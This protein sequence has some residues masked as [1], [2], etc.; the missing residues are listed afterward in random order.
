MNNTTTKTAPKGACDQMGHALMRIVHAFAEADEDAKIFLA[1]WDIKDGFW[2]LNAE[3]GQEWNFSYVMPQ[4]PGEPVRLVV[5]TSLQMGWIESP[6]YFCAAS[7]TARDVAVQYAETEVGSLPVHKF[8]EFTR[9]GK[10]Y[11][12]LPVTA[13]IKDPFAYLVEVF[14]DDYIA[15]AIPTSREQL[16]H[17]ATAVM[18]GV[19]DMFPPDANDEEDSLAL[20]KLKKG[21]SKW[22]PLK[23]VLGFD[24]DGVKK[25]LWLESEKRDVILT[26]LHGWL[27][28]A[29]TKAH[30]IKY[31]EFESTIGKVR[32]AF[33][34]IPAGRGLLSPC[35]AIL[36]IKPPVVYLH[37][38]K[39]LWE[40]VQDCRTLLRE[41]T[42]KPTRC[43]ELVAAWPDY[44]GVKDASGQ[45][46]GG[47]IIGENKECIPTVFRLEW[48]EDI[49]QDLLSQE[50]PNGRITNSDLEMAG[51]LMLWL[52]M[53]D[54][55][56][57]L[58]E[59]HIALFSDNSPT[60]S[61]VERLASK[62]SLVAAQLVRALALR[63]KMQGASPLTPLHIPGRQNAM[64][65][66]PSRSFGSEKKWHFKTDA[67]LLT[68]FNKTFP[69]PKQNSWSAY[70]VSSE[71]AMRVI[72]V[73][74]MKDSSMEE[75]RRLPGAGR[76]IGSTGSAMSHLWELT[77]TYRV[78]TTS[79][80]CGAL[81]DSQVESER[82]RLVEENKS[83]LALSVAH[84]RPLARRSLWPTELTPQS[85]AEP[86]SSNHASK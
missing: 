54:V 72:S 50:N 80:G 68:F 57:P 66:I 64:T 40:A 15:L 82:E 42:T 2:R 85:S 6:P 16:D 47:I 63:I 43:K 86:T 41:S 26:V 51:L 79:I 21:D 1:K 39:F 53:E 14:V 52:I 71:M 45:G 18:T 69:L 19:H 49:K 59:C 35:N 22:L 37:K 62:K 48:P 36:R 24:F 67:A 17:V 7:E 30:G 55:C 65:D 56:K 25:T 4:P 13:P 27:R 60:I 3:A 61:W 44:I 83:K 20:K 10:D 75:W 77:L 78:P 34:S 33:I 12:E 76:H 9:G 81:Q 32:N 84:S 74:R 46:V 58:R 38:N 23:D 5:P 28:A 70:Q 73:L 11:E 29:T 31:E 8:A